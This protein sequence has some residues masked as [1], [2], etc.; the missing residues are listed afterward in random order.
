[1][2][3]VYN[4]YMQDYVSRSPR[5]STHKRR[6]LRDI[7]KNIVKMSASEPLYKIDLSEQK[8]ACALSIKENALSLKEVSHR[9][10]DTPLLHNAGIYS[11]DSEVVSA[12]LLRRMNLDDFPENAEYSIEVTEL[13]AGQ[14]NVGHL[15]PADGTPLKEGSYSFTISF[16]NYLKIK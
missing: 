10:Q 13:A 7:Y 4:Y 9:L 15:L 3:N 14:R 16:S 12:T 2:L 1:M 11:S 8:Q 5:Y 6:E